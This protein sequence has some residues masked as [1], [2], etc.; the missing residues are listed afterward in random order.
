MPGMEKRAHVFIAGRVQGVY[1]RSYTQDMAESLG[2]TGWVRNTRDG[3][4][5]ALFEG[6][7]EAVRDMVEWCRKGSPS[8]RVASIEVAWE[9]ATGEY[10]D[11]S[12]N[13]GY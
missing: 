8:A 10:R 1:F 4:V 12:I 13:Y 6:E 2:L 7:K 11:F 3:R 9:E 5:E